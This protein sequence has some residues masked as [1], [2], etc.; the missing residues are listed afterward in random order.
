MCTVT[1]DR[2]VRD[3]GELEMLDEMDFRV[4]ATPRRV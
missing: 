4:F 1:F 3:F 2:M